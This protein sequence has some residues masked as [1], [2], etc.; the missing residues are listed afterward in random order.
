MCIYIVHCVQYI[1]IYSSNKRF[2]TKAMHIKFTLKL[3]SQIKLQTC[4]TGTRIFSHNRKEPQDSM[5]RLVSLK[6]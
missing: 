5:T 4:F 3:N 1:L 2:K 6:T